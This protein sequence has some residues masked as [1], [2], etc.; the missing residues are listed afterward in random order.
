LHNRV[1][2]IHL[3]T[4]NMIWVFVRK[5]V[6]ISIIIHGSYSIVNML[7][8]FFM[9]LKNYLWF[10]SLLFRFFEKNIS[11]TVNFRSWIWT[12][13]LHFQANQLT[14]NRFCC[15]LICLDFRFY[16]FLCKTKINRGMLS[17]GRKFHASVQCVLYYFFH[18]SFQL[19]L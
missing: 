5:S 4:L 6:L 17:V 8:R 12:I 19:F 1:S 15:D 3:V 18:I 2:I 11:C 10:Y 13:F 9:I 7:L 16:D 14:K